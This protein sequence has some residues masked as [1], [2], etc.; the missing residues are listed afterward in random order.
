MKQFR[1]QALS[2]A[3]KDGTIELALQREPCNEIGSLC[4]EELEQ[5]TSALPE[6]EQSA[7]ALI[8][9]SNLTCG[10][11][12]GA[13]L[14]ELYQRS[15]QM[16]KKDAIAGVQDFLERI[17]HVMNT[18]QKILHPSNRVFLLH[19]LRAL[20]KLT[21]ISPCGESACQIA[22]QNQRMG[23][24]LQLRKRGSELLQFF[25]A[26]GADLIAWLALQREFNGPVF[27]G[28]G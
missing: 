12:A 3:I 17:H 19:L 2:W 10:F 13:D 26:Q 7:H 5:F 20:I 11:S 16:Q 4:L 18:L 24:L 28:P 15:Q 8:L 21:Q 6:L 22:I 9:Y 1:G 27:D 14:R 23:A 25:Q